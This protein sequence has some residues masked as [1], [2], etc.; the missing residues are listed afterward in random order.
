MKTEENDFTRF[1]KHCGTELFFINRFPGNDSTGVK[2]TMR[3]TEQSRRS[4]NKKAAYYENTQD[5]RVTRPLK[6]MIINAVEVQNGQTVVDV[7]CGTGDL[8]AAVAKKANIQVHGIDIAEQMIAV[9][10]ERYQGISFSVAPAYPLAFD[11]LSVDTIM[12]SA[13]FHHFEQPQRFATECKRVLRPG[14]KVYIGEFNVPTVARYIMNF[15]IKFAKT[16][17]VKIYSDLELASFFINAGFE[18]T[19]ILTDGPRIVLICEKR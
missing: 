1:C 14:G 7:A 8:I 2:K 16:G 11:E 4:Y 9:A 18:I 10:K 5:G 15:L 17:D 12:V 3:K 19:D 6:R 13:A